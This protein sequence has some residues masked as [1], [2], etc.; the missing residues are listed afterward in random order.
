MWLCNVSLVI[1]Q[2]FA[3]QYHLNCQHVKLSMSK[4]FCLSS[5]PHI[6]TLCVFSLL[7]I[8]D[9]SMWIFKKHVS[10]LFGTSPH[11]SPFS[12]PPPLTT[13]IIYLW[14]SLWSSASKT[15]FKAPSLMLTCCF[16]CEKNINRLLP[17]LLWFNWDLIEWLR[18]KNLQLVYCGKSLQSDLLSLCFTVIQI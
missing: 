1:Y 14:S 8:H 5:L 16:L 6:H 18:M 7:C 11:G 12:V 15:N 3:S 13:F 17:L 9:Y 10:L 4:W 2:P